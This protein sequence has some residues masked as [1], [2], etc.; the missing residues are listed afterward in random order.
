MPRPYA[1]SRRLKLYAPFQAEF[2]FLHTQFNAI[3]KLSGISANPKI[4][5]VFNSADDLEAFLTTLPRKDRRAFK[6]ARNNAAEVAVDFYHFKKA[7]RKMLD[8]L[9]RL[10]ADADAEK[11]AKSAPIDGIDRAAFMTEAVLAEQNHLIDA[12]NDNFAKH[13]KQK[14]PRQRKAVNY[15][16]TPAMID[17]HPMQWTFENGRYKFVVHQE[18]KDSPF[19]KALKELHKKDRE[20]TRFVRQNG[21]VHAYL[22]YTDLQELFSMLKGSQHELFFYSTPADNEDIAAIVAELPEGDAKHFQHTDGMIYMTETGKRRLEA[23]LQN[24]LQTLLTPDASWAGYDF[25]IDDIAGGNAYIE[26]AIKALRK[27]HPQHHDAFASRKRAEDKYYLT[28]K[29]KELLEDYLP[30]HLI[31]FDNSEDAD[32][33]RIAQLEA[34][35][36]SPQHFTTPIRQRQIAGLKAEERYLAHVKRLNAHIDDLVQKGVIGALEEDERGDDKTIHNL[37]RLDDRYARFYDQTK[38]IELLQQTRPMLESDVFWKS[39][40]RKARMRRSTWVREALLAGLDDLVTLL[41]RNPELSKRA[42]DTLLNDDDFFGGLAWDLGMVRRIHDYKNTRERYYESPQTTEFLKAFYLNED[43]YFKT[44]TKNKALAYK[45]RY[46]HGMVPHKEKV[47]HYAYKYRKWIAG[48]IIVFVLG[49][50]GLS[51]GTRILQAMGFDPA[52]VSASFVDFVRGSGDGTALWIA[53]NPIENLLHIPFLLLPGLILATLVKGIDKGL[54]T[55]LHFFGPKRWPENPHLAARGLNFLVSIPMAIYK[56]GKAC[57]I[58]AWHSIK[59]Y[60]FFGAIAKGWHNAKKLPGQCWAFLKTVPSRV[61]HWI[62]GKPEQHCGHPDHHAKSLSADKIQDQSAPLNG[63]RLASTSPVHVCGKHAHE[64]GKKASTT[65]VTYAANDNTP[66]FHGIGAATRYMHEVV[67]KHNYKGTQTERLAAW[68][69]SLANLVVADYYRDT[70]IPHELLASTEG[71][72]REIFG[73]MADLV[74]IGE[75]KPYGRAYNQQDMLASLK[76]VQQFLLQDRVWEGLRRRQITWKRNYAEERVTAML[77]DAVKLLEGDQFDQNQL[78]LVSNI[79]LR[80]LLGDSYNLLKAADMAAFGKD[81][82]SPLRHN[83]ITAFGD[84]TGIFAGKPSADVYDAVYAFLGKEGKLSLMDRMTSLGKDVI[85]VMPPQTILGW[86]IFFLA[87]NA[88]VPEAGKLIEYIEQIPHY[89]FDVVG[90]ED[91][92]NAIS[93]TPVGDFLKTL[94]EKYN[95]LENASHIPIFLAPLSAHAKEEQTDAR[96]MLAAGVNLPRRLARIVYDGVTYLHHGGEKALF[97]AGEEAVDLRSEHKTTRAERHVSATRETSP[98]PTNLWKGAK[99]VALQAATAIEKSH[100]ASSVTEALGMSTGTFV[101]RYQASR[102]NQAQ[103]VQV[104]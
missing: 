81:A 100:I 33:V 58:E 68:R 25:T 2:D 69:I 27:K 14:A 85:E 59:E 16:H 67:K 6:V 102:V 40:A 80:P 44:H 82:L 38:L 36:E 96:T 79:L 32:K 4:T 41:Q 42:L 35:H 12:N 54:F 37:H 19:Y 8:P 74:P 99:H 83:F 77:S 62:T 61:W 45:F 76:E 101:G 64:H 103:A 63:M 71:R 30:K 23:Q 84:N 75:D 34:F 7:V 95:L 98:K 57:V 87:L 89:L 24:R 31:H 10:E 90:L 13:L 17:K 73:K 11:H 5:I 92:Y 9:W 86:T 29:G 60:G 3:C 48:P 91:W 26:Q 18:Q 39:F 104:Q 55:V 43:E 46:H 65:S 88:A 1:P 78:R 94:F 28:A 15:R 49:V 56:F 70:R 22:T 97:E 50:W 47:K 93:T 72:A 21:E 51:L 20:T 52:G 53:Y 66:I